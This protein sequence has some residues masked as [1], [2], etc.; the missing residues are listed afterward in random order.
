VIGGGITG[1]SAAHRLLERNR[2]THVTVF[3]ASD[4]LG[5]VI[6]TRRE[7][8]FLMEEGADSFVTNKPAGK[9][10]VDRL[11]LGGE[12]IGIA[13]DAR[14]SFVVQNKRLEPTPEGYH[15][16]APSKLGALFSSSLFTPLGK[17]RIAM[18]QFVPPRRQSGD[19]SVGD[20]VLRRFGRED[21]ERMA[22]P[23]VAAI[24]GADAMQLSLEAT[25]PRF[26]EME[27]KYGSVIRGLQQA[28]RDQ[29]RADES[30]Q[31]ASG[32]RY[33]LF[34]TLR[35]GMG[36]LCDALVERLPQSTVRTG[37]EVTGIAP[38]SKGGWTIRM[39][40]GSERYDAVI[41]GIPA[42][43]VS[44]LVAPFDRDL[45]GLLSQISYHSSVTVTLAHHAQ[46]VTHPMD[47][48]GFVVSSS[49][50][51]TLLGCTFGHRKFPSRAPEGEV[52][53][54]TYY[55]NRGMELM[56]E[57]L[58]ASTTRELAPLLGIQGEPIL[59]R[60]ARWPGGMPQY[61]VGHLGLVS[62]IEKQAATHS[63]FALAGN[64]YRGVGIPD[65]IQ[66]AEAAVDRIMDV[67]RV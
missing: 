21:L 62:R 57:D 39:S 26:L 60:V 59:T 17:L 48:A 28:L 64:G 15:L 45:A 47:G 58:L 55:G 9:A 6:S 19:E 36:T 24:Y 43:G 50:G 12:L 33:G 31:P 5:G 41:L 40:G 27:Q 65:C 61:A 56:D 1:L 42:P 66:S 4:R 29:T 11:G 37:T 38:A 49:E 23:M 10:L 34:V 30:A 13:P 53:L 52:L 67:A 20:F 44:R 16:L 7:S 8:G 35:K 63:G 22:K 14:Q 25:F 46:D 2:E 54:R 32:P 3:E 18:E 51:M